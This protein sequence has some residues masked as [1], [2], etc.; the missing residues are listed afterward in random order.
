[1]RNLE[2]F[3]Y[4][5]AFVDYNNDGWQDILLVARPHPILYR[6]KGGGKFEDVTAAMGLTRIR[7]YWTGCAVA[8]FDGDG[9][10]DLLLTGFS[11]LALLKNISGHGFQDVTVAAGLD[12]KNHGNWGSSAGFMDL[13]GSSALDL[14]IT[15]YVVFGPHEKQYCELRPG[16]RSGCP[17]D[18]YRPQFPELWKND[19]HGHFKNITS[20]SG[21]LKTHGKGL[22]LAFADYDDDGRVDFYIGNDGTPAELMRNLGGLRF[23]NVGVETGIA[24]GAMN[25]ALAAM[26]ADWGDY[27]RDGKLDLAVTAFSDEPY[28]L[29]RNLGRGAFEQMNDTLGISGPTFK[30]LGFGAKWI[31]VDNNGWP[32]LAFANGHV[33]D[34][35]DQI[36]PLETFREPMMLFQ[37]ERARQ[38]VDLVPDIGGDLS[39]PIVGRGSAVGDYNNDGRQDLLVVDME[40]TPLLLRNDTATANHWITL[41]LRG[42]RNRFAY[43]AKVTARTGHEAWVGLVSPASSYLSSSDP[44]IHFG[45]GSTNHLDELTIRWSDGRVKMLRQLPVDRILRISE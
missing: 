1:M 34:N 25:H 20:S 41:D 17:P 16:I 38:F 44:R 42:T 13:T 15:N 9:Y 29:L 6:N 32:D 7:G 14:V 12:P 31:D 22:V 19:G 24:Y 18:E 40:G 23:K 39:K 5:C 21:L 30:T 43:G 37:N 36:D 27:D 4:G 3:G 11:R 8:D 28:S 35:V 2:A 33:Y 10:L 26:G 45:L